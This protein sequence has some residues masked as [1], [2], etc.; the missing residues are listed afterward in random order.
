M[1]LYCLLVVAIPVALMGA[2]LWSVWGKFD[3]ELK[4]HDE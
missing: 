1:T 3:D 4:G 2:I